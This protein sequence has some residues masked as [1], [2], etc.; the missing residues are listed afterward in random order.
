LAVKI[1]LRRMGAKKRP[2]Y[3]LV[4]AD[5]RS[6]RDGRFIEAVGTYDPLQNPALVKI[7]AERVK[8][9]MSKGA[10]PTDMARQLL[11]S[12][13][14][15]ERTGPTFSP[16][17]K[18][19]QLSKKAQAK[20]AA[21][22]EASAAAA[23][24]PAPEPEAATPEATAPAPEPEAAAPEA[25]AAEASAEHAELPAEGAAEGETEAGPTAEHTTEPAEGAVVEAEKA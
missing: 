7:D 18:K 6:P 21:E 10:R 5:A 16:A 20:K 3:R 23:A 2:F 13:G 4:V 22:A 8:D 19:E 24:A 1:R 14:V 11:V 17:E 25:G 12:E 9:W 15:I